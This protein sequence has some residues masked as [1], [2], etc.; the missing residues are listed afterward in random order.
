MTTITALPTPPSRSD[1]TNFAARGDAFNGALPNFVTE[2]NLVAR[3]VNTNATTAVTAANTAVA[4]KNDAQTSADAAALSVSQAAAAAGATKWASDFSY[5]DGAVV[6][7][8][9]NKFNYRRNS[10]GS[11]TT[12]PSRDSTNWTLL[13]AP[14]A[15]PSASINSD[16]VAAPGVAYVLLPPVVAGVPYTLSFPATPADRMTVDV[17]NNSGTR[18][19]QIYGNGKSIRG[20]TDYIQLFDPNFTRRFQ[21]VASEDKWL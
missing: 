20:T 14:L 10:A 15:P 4:A 13:G 6:W 1:P 9:L 12:D 11:S 7:S 3:E 21:W 2:T 18:I 5:A 8:P 16:T 19:V 17:I